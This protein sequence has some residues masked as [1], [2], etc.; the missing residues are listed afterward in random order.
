MI[1][2]FLHHLSRTHVIIL[3]VTNLAVLTAGIFWMVDGNVLPLLGASFVHLTCT[4]FKVL[5][6][7]GSVEVAETPVNNNITV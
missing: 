6:G 3:V 5:Q 7:V 1:M 4:A 2:S